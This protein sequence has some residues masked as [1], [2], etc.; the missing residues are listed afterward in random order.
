[1]TRVAGIQISPVF[2]DAEKTWSKLKERIVEAKEHGADFVTW[3][4]TLIP[5]YP[6]WISPSG[7]AKFNNPDQKK[8]YAKY[9]KEAIHLD[10]SKILTEMKQ[11]AKKHSI[12]MMGGIAEKFS[13]STYCTLL[14]IG[15]NGEIL[16][17]HRKIK[18]TYEEK[19]V[20]GDGD[21]EGLKTYNL[22]G[23]K[24]GGLNCWENWLPLPRAALHLQ[25]EILHVA[26]WPGGLGLTQEITRFIALEGRSW[27]MSTSGMLGPDDFAHLSEKEFP[28]KKIM[29]EHKGYWQNGGSM[30]VDPTGKT[31]AGP[32]VGEEGIIYADVD[33]MLA[34]EERQ[35]LDI[36]GHYSRFD[37]FNKP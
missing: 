25:E 7:G 10:D 28:M 15:S 14:T 22:K 23:F 12:M 16:G 29:M 3:G 24:V 30:I 1:M 35:T 36:S 17:R 9:W 19:L 4:E 37:L 32:L 13:G 34:I 2:L 20:W 6:Q 33:P 11:L 18:P 26:V 5:G 8:A 27:V 31:V 21:R